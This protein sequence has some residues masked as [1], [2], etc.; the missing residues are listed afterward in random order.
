MDYEEFHP[1]NLKNFPL[2][3]RRISPRNSGELL[4]KTLENLSHKFWK[5]SL[6]STVKFLPEILD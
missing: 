6:R 3:F 5:N 2:K 4:L 1:E